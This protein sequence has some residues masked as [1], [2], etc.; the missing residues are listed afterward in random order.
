MG[1]VMSDYAQEL[2][3]GMLQ[4]AIDDVLRACKEVNGTT[5]PSGM[6]LRVTSE[7]TLGEDYTTKDTQ[8]KVVINITEY[9]I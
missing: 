3:T 1:R 9:Q 7:V 5:T 2:L 8:V 4:N 6:R